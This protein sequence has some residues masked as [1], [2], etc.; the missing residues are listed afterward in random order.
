M[1]VLKPSLD[2]STLAAEQRVVGT[3]VGTV[4]AAVFL[5]TIANTLVLG[6]AIVVI[7]ALSA[8]LR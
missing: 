5:L 6:L 1:L 4:V 2:Q 8:N 7:A 3:L